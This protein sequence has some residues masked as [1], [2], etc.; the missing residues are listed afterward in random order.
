ML[1]RLPVLM[2]GAL[3]ASPSAFAQDMPPTAA[4]CSGCHGQNGWGLANVAPMLA[5]LDAGYL[6]QQIDL[7]L[8]GKRKD[9]IMTAMSATVSDPAIRKQ[10]SEYYASLPAPKVAKPEQRGDRVSFT[11]AAEKL[12]YQ[13]DWDRNIPACATCHGPSGVGVDHFP[14]LAGQQEYYL[15][16]QLND[17]KQG[18]RSGDPLNM[19]SHIA[20]QLTTDEIKG[21][22]GFFSTLPSGGQ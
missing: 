20:V 21:L 14:R 7:F 10:V 16:K 9:P 5:G 13:G 4:V 18:K 6:S 8:T 22:A 12:A 2:F 1:K 15:A 19:M 11:S 3:L 17:W